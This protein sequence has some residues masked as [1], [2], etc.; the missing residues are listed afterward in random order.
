MNEDLINLDYKSLMKHVPMPRSKRAA[1]FSPFAALTGYEE[2]ICEESR[3]TED[4]RY[5]TNDEAINL[6]NKIQSSIGKEVKITFF[7]K[8]KTKSGGKYLTLDSIITK[9][10]IEKQIIQLANGITIK[11]KDI[12]ALE[13]KQ[14]KSYVE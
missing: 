12:I 9:I 1:Q 3:V 11:I 13:T 10:F 14:N 2:A 4:R 5:L 6:N 8:D 7:E